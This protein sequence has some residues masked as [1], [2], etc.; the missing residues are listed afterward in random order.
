MSGKVL[1]SNN[2]ALSINIE[3]YTNGIYILKFE[4]DEVVVFKKL[5]INK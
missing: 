1:Y 3:E 2:N 5:I 4:T